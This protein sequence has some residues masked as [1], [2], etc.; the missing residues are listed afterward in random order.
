MPFMCFRAVTY[1]QSTNRNTCLCIPNHLISIPLRLSLNTHAQRGY[2]W[3]CVRLPPSSF[4]SFWNREVNEKEC[5][6][7]CV[8]NIS[9]WVQLFDLMKSFHNLLN[10]FPPYNIDNA[11]NEPPTAAPNPCWLCTQNLQPMLSF[12]LDLNLSKIFR[13]CVHYW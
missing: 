12:L 2:I 4:Y 10:Y 9:N 1:R 13:N 11:I 6:R 8:W 7:V 5:V 3:I